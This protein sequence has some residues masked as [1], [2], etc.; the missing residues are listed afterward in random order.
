MNRL[1]T[2]LAWVI[3]TLV[4]IPII[5][6][7]AALVTPESAS[8]SHLRET[9]LAGYVV[10][11]IALTV[12]VGGLA[13]LIG[14]AAAW[15]VATR[16]FPGRRVFSW[17]L[18]LPL[19]APAYVVAYV[20]TDLLEFAGPLQ[21]A[22]RAATG[23]AA[24]DYWFPPIRSLP[25]AALV[26]SL[27]LYPYVYLLART[28]FETQAASLFEAARVLGA[29]PRRAFG[30]VALPAARP[31]I[32]GGVALAMMETVADYGV[33]DYFGVSTFTTGIFRTWFAL[34]DRAAA[35]ELAAWLFV[36]ALVLVLAEH[37]ARRGRY[38]NPV[39]RDVVAPRLL[40][41]GTRA[42]LATIGCSIPVLLGFVVPVGVL[43][44]HAVAL[45]DPLFGTGFGDFVTNSV[46]VASATAGVATL[47]AV[48]LAYSGRLSGGRSTGL[49]L[50]AATLGYALPGTVV[51][52]GVLVP[53]AFLDKSIARFLAGH[54][55]DVGLLLTG[56]V[57]A[58]VFTY[59]VRFLT[60]AYNACD[61]GMAKVHRN[62]DAAARTLG[63][64]PRRVLAAVHFPL[65]RA[66]LASAALL[67][68]I[69]V[70]KEL[71]AT[72]ILRPFNFETLATRVY[73]LASDERLA[74]ASTAA[75]A[76][77]LVGVVPVV[78]LNLTSARRRKDGGIVQGV[79][80]QGVGTRHG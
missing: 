60:V 22:L 74:E 57:A 46:L 11:T 70:M 7:A 72:L 38:S 49:A 1:W 78:L 30:T 15:T 50:R 28:A 13:A 75:L 3:A 35:L 41:H 36:L 34:G 4:G 61:G 21:S 5:V 53:L 24:G 25:G 29:P 40:L 73:R 62:L 63:A 79:L 16:E 65:T 39:A 71:P 56:T 47:L 12:A 69:D 67:V 19:A 26:L 10:N 76:I 48:C 80:N 6:V 18:V 59:V 32:A 20:Y 31:I 17:A 42:A 52:V 44:A 77:V 55:M 51:A 45:G 54:G 8:W 2:V 14:V 64:T 23:W 66:A 37:T 58:L 9:V 68:F 43:A 27:V 33:V